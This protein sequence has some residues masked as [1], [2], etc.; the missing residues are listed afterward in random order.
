MKYLFQVFGSGIID[1]Q[2]LLQTNTTSQPALGI[3]KVRDFL[4]PYPKVREEVELINDVLASVDDRISKA[5][6]KLL[7]QLDLKKPLCKT[8]SP[9]RC[10]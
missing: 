2:V 9:A 10:A 5:N 6:D 1:Q 3:K 8:C 7:H 4:V